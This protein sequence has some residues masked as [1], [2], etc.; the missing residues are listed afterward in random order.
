MHRPRARNSAY[1][2][3]STRACMRARGFSSASLGGS[4][5]PES[6]P[7]QRSGL[8]QDGD[9][10]ISGRRVYTRRP[11]GAYLHARTRAADTSPSASRRSHAFSLLA[12]AEVSSVSRGGRFRRRTVMA[13]S[14]RP[15]ARAR[16]HGGTSVRARERV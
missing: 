12:R 8:V 3:A 1:V 5:P 2:R 6:L 14:S 10:A 15:R 13:T 4:R 16:S 7:R 9:A 11:R